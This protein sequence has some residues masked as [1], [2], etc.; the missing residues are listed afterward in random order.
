MGGSANLVGSAGPSGASMAAPPTPRASPPKTW[1]VAATT[2]WAAPPTPKIRSQ[3][4][5]EFRSELDVSCPELEQRRYHGPARGPS[6]IRFLANIGACCTKF[7]PHPSLQRP[8]RSEIYRYT[9]AFSRTTPA[10][11]LGPPPGDPPRDPLMGAQPSCLQNA[12]KSCLISR[13]TTPLPTQRE[14]E[15]RPNDGARPA[16][17]ACARSPLIA[18]QFEQRRR[19][20][21]REREQQ[22]TRIRSPPT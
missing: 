20:P 1:A 21:W 16:K 12:P 4:R 15:T 9:L 8:V 5:P 7:H 11:D 18:S 10:P 14:C 6:H 13:P 3:G 19:R 2:P 17:E 22:I